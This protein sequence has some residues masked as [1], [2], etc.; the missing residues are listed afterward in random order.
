MNKYV[1]MWQSLFNSLMG[2]RVA[3][4]YEKKT[5]VP[6]HIVKARRAA[7]YRA[8]ASRRF[9]RLRAKGHQL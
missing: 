6:R 8:R 2:R 1:N 4:T 5:S 3:I 7:N 9:N